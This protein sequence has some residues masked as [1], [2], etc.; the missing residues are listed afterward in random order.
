LIND[1]IDAAWHYHNGTKHPHG[2]L[3]SNFYFYDPA[4][5]PTPYKIYTENLQSVNLPLEKKPVGK[6][7]FAAISDNIKQDDKT[8][9][10]DLNTLSRILYFSNGITKTIHYPKLGDMEFRAAACTGALYHIEIY[11]VCGDIPGLVQEC[12]TL[13]PRK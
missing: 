5:R 4:F 13:T 10:P 2:K 11:V 6:G 8:V 9:V 1:N 12:I 3:H 7:T